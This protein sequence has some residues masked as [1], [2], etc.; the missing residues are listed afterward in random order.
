MSDTFT[1]LLYFLSA[2]LQADAAILGLGIVFIVYRMQTLYSEYQNWVST[3]IPINVPAD[4]APDCDKL[5]RQG[6][7]Q[8]E[9]EEILSRRR[10]TRFGVAFESIAAFPTNRRNEMWR[11]IPPI[12]MVG[13]HCVIT[14]VTLWSLYCVSRASITNSTL[15]FGWVILFSFAVSLVWLFIA[16]YFSLK[17]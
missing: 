1:V 15:F 11:L 16:A 8:V 12:A 3:L 17:R 9:I 7:T 5:L 4:V 6:I 10:P 14:A 13:I 2:I